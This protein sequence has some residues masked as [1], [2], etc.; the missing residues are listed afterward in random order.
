[1]IDPIMRDA[2]SKMSKSVEHFANELQTIRTGRAN[3]ALIDRIMVPYY[4]TPTPL[5]QLAQIS[6][7]E[8][9]LL[10][11]SVYDKSQ[12]GAVEKALRTSEQGLNPASDGQVIRVP[13]PALT[14]E[15]RREYVKLVKQRAEEA[16]VAIRN[17]RRDELHRIEQM[18]KKGDV[19]EDESKRASA[20]LQK[21]TES[22]IEKVDG[23]AARKEHEVMEV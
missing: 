19:A 22:Q 5:N 7:P 17:V 1:M 14:E 11:V 21:I 23:L 18:Q 12:I 20:R 3:P 2:E 4:G 15:R 13:I 10:V 9:R 8:P 6:V 16:R